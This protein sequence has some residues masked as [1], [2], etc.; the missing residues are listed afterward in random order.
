MK[1]PIRLKKA[2]CLGREPSDYACFCSSTYVNAL[3]Y[4]TLGVPIPNPN[5]F[6]NGTDDSNDAD[7]DGSDLLHSTTED[8]MATTE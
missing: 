8:P 2:E 1:Y 6:G 3:A 7:G 4:K 5:N